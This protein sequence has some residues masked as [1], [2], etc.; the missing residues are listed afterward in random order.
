MDLSHFRSSR[1]P[2]QDPGARQRPD[3]LRVG[4]LGWEG[5]MRSLPRVLSSA[6]SALIDAF[7]RLLWI[8]LGKGGRQEWKESETCL[9]PSQQPGCSPGRVPEGEESRLFA[10]WLKSVFHLKQ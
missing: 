7:Q 3:D 10:V 9:N 5:V 6:G 1:L 4:K 8:P 2:G